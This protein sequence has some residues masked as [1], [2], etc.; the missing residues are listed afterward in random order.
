MQK[1]DVI[2]GY[3]ILRDF[4]VVGAGLSKWTFARKDGRD[5]FM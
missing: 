5:Y 4:S 1:G 3:E 2:G